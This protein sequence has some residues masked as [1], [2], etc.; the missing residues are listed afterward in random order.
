MLTSSCGDDG[1]GGGAGDASG[2]NPAEV[3]DSSNP[4]QAPPPHPLSL[5][6]CLEYSAARAFTK[7]V[8]EDPEGSHHYA[9][10]FDAI[11]LNDEVWEV[12][13]HFHERDNL[14]RSL[15]VDDIIFII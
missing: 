11:S 3:C 4:S 1:G 14:E 5:A 8:K 9:S 15:N 2:V 7:G 12:G 10:S 6:Y 13:F